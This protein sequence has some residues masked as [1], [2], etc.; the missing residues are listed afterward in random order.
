[1][2]K[3]GSYGNLGRLEQENLTC[4]DYFINPDFPEYIFEGPEKG[5]DNEPVFGE[6]SIPTRV[7]K[8][9][10]EHSSLP[11][12]HAHHQCLKGSPRHLL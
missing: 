11:P 10:N 3:E 12:L 4:F 1:M 2:M 9:D 7:F 8:V 5:P 6:N